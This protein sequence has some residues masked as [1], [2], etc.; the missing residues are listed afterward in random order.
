M[1][2]Y[3][4]IY[5]YREREREIFLRQDVVRRLVGE[6]H[7]HLGL[8]VRVGE[9]AVRRLVR[10][11][12]ARAPSDQGHLRALPRLVHPGEVALALV[13]DRSLYTS[14]NKYVQYLI[15]NRYTVF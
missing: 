5:A 7:L 2:T 9:D 12:D 14:T 8:V 4:Y 13:R 15:N 10:Q 3:I 1:I 11:G 6:E